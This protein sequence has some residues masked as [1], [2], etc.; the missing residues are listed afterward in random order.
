[1]GIDALA[2]AEKLWQQSHQE[3]SAE[4]ARESADQETAA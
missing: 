3:P 4:A 2:E 1:M